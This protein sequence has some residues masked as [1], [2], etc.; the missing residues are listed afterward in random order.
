MSK[1]DNEE[2]S[3]SGLSEDELSDLLVIESENEYMLD[4]EESQ[5]SDFEEA[6]SESQSHSDHQ[7][8]PNSPPQSS[9]EY[10][11]DSPF[12]FRSDSEDSDATLSDHDNKKCRHPSPDSDQ[13]QRE[14]NEIVRDDTDEEE[15][16]QSEYTQSES[17]SDALVSTKRKSGRESRPP[18]RLT[19]LANSAELIPTGTPDP[20]NRKAM[21]A[22]PY[23]ELWRKTE[24]Q[25]MIDL[26]NLRMSRLVLKSKVPAARRL[27]VKWV[28]MYKRD[29]NHR[30]YRLKAR[31]VLLGFLQR[32]GV[33]YQQTYAG[34]THMKTVR[35]LLAITVLMDFE[36]SHIDVC[37]AF[38]NADLD[39]EVYINYPPGFVGDQRYV[40]QLLKALPGLKQ[41]SRAWWKTMSSELE[42]YGIRAVSADPSVYVI[43]RGTSLLIIA[44]HVDDLLLVCNDRSLRDEIIT[45]FRKRFKFRDYGLVEK[46]IGIKIDQDE[47]SIT[48]QQRAY[49][50]DANSTLQLPEA[51]HVGM[52]IKPKAEFDKLQCPVGEE[53]KKV[54]AGVPYRS[55]IG[56]TLWVAGATRPDIAYATS[57]FAQFSQNPARI[58]WKGVKQ[59]FAY[60]FSTK[61]QGITYRRPQ[62]RKKDAIR[63]IGYSDSDW[64][65]DKAD[66]RSRSGGVIYLAGAPVVWFSKKQTVVAQSSCEAEYV[67]L[68][69]LVREFLWLKHLLT[70]LTIPFELPFLAYVDNKAAR[71]LAENPIRHNRSKH[72][73]IKFHFIL[74]AVKN[75][76]VLILPVDSKDNVADLFTKPV[77]TS[78][79]EHLKQKL[80]SFTM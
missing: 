7:S 16:E 61:H 41:A 72:I 58:H 12:H 49:V 60:L 73:D 77:S 67:A 59:L 68:S 32:Y 38:P 46:Y 29:D 30:I 33:D 43:R 55:G 28:Y 36:A 14:I 5:S 74:E 63:P 70:E 42:K 39:E 11:L 45:L 24:H 6:E 22:G 53:E 3:D 40:V 19:F 52:P 10:D 80:F 13:I 23:A 64:G 75:N 37:D 54:M 79:F 21:L 50:E 27:P 47:D 15:S 4:E 56:K 51:K 25:H 2:S 44:A 69:E 34:V 76:Y 57:T 35:V 48:L 18:N 17:D 8:P 78:I 62:G 9:S 66:R 31:L 71:E 20:K 65:T 1:F 26:N